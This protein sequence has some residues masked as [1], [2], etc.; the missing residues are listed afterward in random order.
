LTTKIIN[1]KLESLEDYMIRKVQWAKEEFLKEKKLPTKE[2][3]K[4]KAGV[5]NK[6][7]NESEKVQRAIDR[8]FEELHAKL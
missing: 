6:T 4:M 5:K 1:E 7:S 2:Q 8:A 3:L